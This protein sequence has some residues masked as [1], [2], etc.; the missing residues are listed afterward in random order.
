MCEDSLSGSRGHDAVH[1]E[2]GVLLSLGHEVVHELL[3]VQ[4]A[5]EASF[6]E[7][8]VAGES[9]GIEFSHHVALGRR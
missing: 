6:R 8:E 3:K 1:Q 4:V 9:E 2:P 5:H 7:E